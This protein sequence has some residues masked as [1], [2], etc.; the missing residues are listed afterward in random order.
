MVVVVLALVVVVV[1]TLVVLVDGVEEGVVWLVGNGVVVTVVWL[2]VELEGGVVAVELEEG[3]VELEEGVVAV[4]LEEGVVVTSDV[5]LSYR[6]VTTVSATARPTASTTRNATPFVRFCSRL[7]R[8]SH[9]MA[10]L[11]YCLIH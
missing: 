6:M 8:L 3:V 10:V 11:Y 9:D 2:V 7:V 4:E 5:S 1:V